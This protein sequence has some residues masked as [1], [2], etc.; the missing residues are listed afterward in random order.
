MR[1]NWLEC[2][3]ASGGT[4]DLALTSSNG[5]PL[6]SAWISGVR[7]VRYSILEFNSDPSSTNATLL[8]AEDGYCPLDASGPTLKRSDGSTVIFS[9]WN[10][11]NL[12]PKMASST[13]ASKQS[14][15]TSSSNIRIICSAA[16]EDNP[17]L[18]PILST[19]AG[20]GSTIG[21]GPILAQANFITSTNFDSYTMGST[22]VSQRSQQLGY[23]PICWPNMG[24]YSRITVS[25]GG[26]T[27]ATSSSLQLG[28][29]EVSKNGDPGVLLADFGNLGSLVG[30]A[31]LTSSA[32]AT[33][34]LLVPGWYYLA[35]LPIFTGETGT[36]TLAC[37]KQWASPGPLGSSANNPGIS[38]SIVAGQTIL[39]NPAVSPT[40]TFRPNPTAISG[41]GT[42]PFFWLK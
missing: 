1:Q 10:G 18:S 13:A 23:I 24:L 17:F 35:V 9:S 27:S 31:V 8:L 36:A 38:G 32:L 42:V 28:L 30:N 19:T 39:T 6:L 25:V 16:A 34:V 20:V 2:T 11:T 4:G 33:P 29:Y 14:F 7:Q 40:T 21:C 12:F 5:F 37:G 41:S 22:G 3:S 15:S 26:F